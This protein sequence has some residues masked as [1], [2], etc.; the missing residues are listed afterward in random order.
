MVGRRDRK[1]RLSGVRE[2]R[3]LGCRGGLEEAEM[4]IGE[5]AD[6]CGV[7]DEGLKL[8]WR[9]LGLGAWSRGSCCQRWQQASQASRGRELGLLSFWVL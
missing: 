5:T 4:V 1:Y 2:G 3:G 7:G 6:G 9:G 8:R